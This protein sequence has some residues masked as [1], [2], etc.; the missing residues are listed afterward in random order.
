[1]FRRCGPARH[2]SIASD[3][4]IQVALNPSPLLEAADVVAHF[5][6]SLHLHLRE[7]SL[8]EAVEGAADP[9]PAHHTVGPPIDEANRHVSLGLRKRRARQQ[10]PDH[11]DKPSQ[12]LLVCER[13]MQSGA[14]ALRRPSH[15]HAA[16]VADSPHFPV[17]DRVN[18]VSGFIQRG[19]ARLV[20]LPSGGISEVVVPGEG[21]SPIPGGD[22]PHWSLGENDLQIGTRV[23]GLTVKKEWGLRVNMRF[24]IELMQINERKKMLLLWFENP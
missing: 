7:A 8:L 14:T 24:A 19:L 11:A 5:S 22:I 16:R 15:K 6:L 10:V 1:M 4:G 18:P 17:D 2:A 3:H 20:L 12:R 13:T 23:S 9:M 21:L